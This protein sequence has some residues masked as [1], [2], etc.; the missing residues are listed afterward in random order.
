MRTNLKVRAGIEAQLAVLRRRVGKL[1][2]DL[3]RETNP[4]DRDLEDQALT[5][6]NDDVVQ[7]LLTEG[8]A[9][10]AAL[11]SALQRIEAGAYGTCADCGRPIAEARLRALPH[12]THCIDCA[13]K[14]A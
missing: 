13:R 2:R 11:E 4:L 12:A 8:L 1:E 5:R 10:I 7:G 14:S 9:Q 3:R 6:E